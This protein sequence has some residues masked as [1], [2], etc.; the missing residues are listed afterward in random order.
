MNQEWKNEPGMLRKPER[1]VVPT[2]TGLCIIRAQDILYCKVDGNYTEFHLAN[3]AKLLC[4]I[5]L[6]EFE[7]GIS[8]AD[9]IFFRIHK[10]YVINM[11]H[12]TEYR[13]HR[14]RCVLLTGD[15]SIPVA[16]RK[17]MAFKQLLGHC[18]GSLLQVDT[19]CRCRNKPH[20]VHP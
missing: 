17:V 5:S 1:I 7:K 11:D 9:T 15:I 6:C 10:S 19:P 20:C 4:S 8:E 13:N 14:E 16:H 2:Q 18:Y 12:V 3:G